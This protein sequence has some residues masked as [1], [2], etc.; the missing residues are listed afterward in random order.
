VGGEGG[1]VGVVNLLK[2]TSKNVI[3]FLGT[4]TVH[5]PRENPGYANTYTNTTGAAVNFNAQ[6]QRSR[7]NVNEI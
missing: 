3:N 7:S 5:P 1:N 6:G 4:K 2:T